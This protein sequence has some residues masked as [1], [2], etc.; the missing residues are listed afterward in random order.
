MRIF[1]PIFAVA[2][3]AIGTSFSSA[4]TKP[5]RLDAYGQPLPDGAIARLGKLKFG[6]LG[7]PM[8]VAW[9]P[10][11]KKLAAV[12][13]DK[14][15]LL[16]WE[17]PSGKVLTELRLPNASAGRM[18]FSPDGK[19]LFWTDVH[20]AWHTSRLWNVETMTEVE[21]PGQLR[22]E[23][24][25]V[26]FSRDG[27]RL[28]LAGRNADVVEWTIGA[29]E[30]KIHRGSSASDFAVHY[31]AKNELI[32]ARGSGDGV[33][34]KNLATDTV[35][36]EFEAPGLHFRPIAL[37]PDGKWIAYQ[38]E[39]QKVVV[40]EIGET[41]EWSLP[42]NKA[43]I[44]AS[45]TF[46]PDAKCLAVTLLGHMTLLDLATGKPRFDKN[47]SMFIEAVFSPDGEWFATFGGNHEH[48]V[49]IFDA[50]TGESVPTSVGHSS[51]VH[52]TYWTPDGKAVMTH[53]PM[54][55]DPF[56]H[57]WEP[58]T[59]KLIRSWDVGSWFPGVRWTADGRTVVSVG[60]WDKSK[61][62]QVWDADTLKST[63]V[64]GNRHPQLAGH[65][66]LAD[67]GRRIVSSGVG[68]YPDDLMLWDFTTGEKVWKEPLKTQQFVSAIEFLL[69]DDEILIVTHDGLWIIGQDDPGRPKL[70]PYL[71]DYGAVVALSPD[72]KLLAVTHSSSTKQFRVWTRIVEVATGRVVVEL[73]SDLQGNAVAFSPDGRT[74]IVGT[75]V[76][77]LQFF[78]VS[79]G[80]ILTTL[81]TGSGYGFSVS[82][83]GKLL[84]CPGR[85]KD[86]ATPLVWDV[87]RWVRRARSDVNAATAAQIANWTRQLIDPEPA[88]AIAAAW[89]LADNP[90]Q[91]V[92]AL[93]EMFERS[94]KPDAA[95]IA[96]LIAEL[97]DAKFTV[98]EA[99]TR[100]LFRFGTA[101]AP[102]VAN[103][104]KAGGSPERM[105]R[106][107]DLHTRLTDVAASPEIL[108]ASRAV[109][110]L[111]QAG[112]AEARELLE[113]ATK[114]DPPSR[115]TQEA[116]WALDRLSRVH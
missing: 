104:L 113:T 116:K 35:G 101:A 31:S 105:K 12:N 60:S 27:K 86:R 7:S 84:V 59:G 112:T 51:P 21:R 115:L 114:G 20:A 93:R 29:A 68:G 28:A 30:A 88:G 23:M 61:Q 33:T 73:G 95:T 54:R 100:E 19:Y 4:D 64:F 81:D 97:D 66:A 65:F 102:A 24:P 58:R 56:I 85:D 98:R 44:P 106:L 46:T 70:R 10:D 83:D 108:F 80:N 72:K 109:M 26:A 37:S 48:A 82:P 55:G 45:L 67:D 52:R 9:S 111:E 49:L 17:Y 74:C 6:L 99:A 47:H 3:I 15:R 1:I 107:R 53:A 110:A 38:R 40:R 5:V 43:D 94:P 96:K 32:I 42:I 78:D 41:R 8:A 77:Q 34:V 79:T 91:A 22:G 71:K 16:I 62:F 76:D 89:R 2:I 87:E 69:G 25:A 103:A 50:K 36:P 13:N 90:K 39:R 14:P 63:R 75:M 57:F 92:P 18:L 11:G